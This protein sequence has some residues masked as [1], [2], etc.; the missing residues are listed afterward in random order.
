MGLNLRGKPMADRAFLERFTKELVDKGK[1][2]EA[3]WISMRLA[4]DLVDAPPDQLREMR[5]AFFGGAQ[6]LLGSMM[7]FLDPGEEP[8]DAD[9]K[10]MDMIHDELDA[11][12]KDFA[13]HHTTTKGT[14]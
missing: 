3:G 9:M 10:R 2:I 13:L 14:A 6:H 8:T 5:M 12:I 7:T 1:L 11:F 4:C